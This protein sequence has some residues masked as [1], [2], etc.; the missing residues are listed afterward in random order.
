MDEEQTHQSMYPASNVFGAT[1]H[2]RYFL[3]PR[4]MVVLGM[5]THFF[6]VNEEIRVGGIEQ[7]CQQN[8]I[9]WFDGQMALF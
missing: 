7:V 1:T 5:E 6:L 8:G 9:G 2:F 3:G 4:A